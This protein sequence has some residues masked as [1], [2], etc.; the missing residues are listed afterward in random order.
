MSNF[1]DEELFI[2]REYARSTLKQVKELLIGEPRLP[3]DALDDV[4]RQ[5]KPFV[6]RNCDASGPGG[7]F[8]L[9]M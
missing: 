6:I 7:M 1:F 3:H 2:R 9:D 4:L 8:H 5:I